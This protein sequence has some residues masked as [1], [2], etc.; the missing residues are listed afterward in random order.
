ML[1][2]RP[3]KLNTRNSYATKAFIFVKIPI[4]LGYQ[5][6][7][8]YLE[9]CPLKT[10]I[11]ILVI[12]NSAILAQATPIHDLTDCETT[13]GW[14]NSAILSANAPQGQFAVSASLP[15]NQ[16]GFVTFDFQNKGM[17]IS[18]KH[19]L[20]FWW[21][22]EGTGLKDLKIKVRNYPLVGGMEAIYTI[23]SGQTPPVGWQ[24]AIV[25][26]SKPQYDDWGGSPDLTRR[27]ITFR[28]E[29]GAQ[30][31]VQLFIDH[32]VAVD[33]I[34]T[35]TVASPVQT[36]ES[37]VQFDFDKDGSV[38]FSDFLILAQAFG[39]QQ[40]DPKF[41]SIVDINQDNTINFSDFVSF[42][43]VFGS[44]GTRWTIPVIIN[45]TTPDALLFQIGSQNS[46]LVTKS[47]S[48][49]TTQTITIPLDN[50]RFSGRNSAT[51][52]PIPLWVQV[53]GYP[54]TRQTWTTYVP[55][56]GP[57]RTYQQFV[58]AKQTQA[59]PIL[60]DFSYSGY[61][62]FAKSIP[63]IQ[64]DTF[65]VITFGAIPNDNQSDQLGIQRA[66]DAAERNNG[67]IVFF[68]PGEFLVNTMNDNNQSIFIR[69]SNIV[70]RGSGSRTGGTIIKMINHMPPTNPTQLWTSPYMFIFKPLNTS[71]K[72]LAQITADANRETFWITV[73]DVSNLFV[74]QWIILSMT[75]VSAVA[76]FLFPYQPEPSWTTIYSGGVQ[77]R[78]KHSIAEIQG[79]RV[80]INEPLHAS[81]NAL[82]GWTVR[83]Y[84]HLNEVGVED[85]CFMGNW[86]E[87]FV[88]HKDAIHDG[89]WSLLQLE[90]C[91]NSWV[92]RCS[93]IHAN[94]ALDIN[95]CSATSVYHITQ[96]GNKGHSSIAC[97][98]G[99]GVWIGLSEDLSAHHHGPGT[100]SRA[101]GTVYWR[102]DMQP[103]QRIDAHGAQPYANLLDC[104]NGGILYGSGA[105]I[106]NFP[107][108]LKHYVLWNFLHRGNQTHYDFW[109]QGQSRDRF[110]KP[111]IVGFHGDSVTFNESTLQVNE[112]HGSPV[113]PE[114][115]FEA[116]LNLRTGLAFP[117]WLNALKIEW[118]Q[119]RQTP[120]PNFPNTNF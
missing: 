97:E 29:T 39:T 14:S 30:S 35:W 37:I 78:E 111:I 58:Q 16:T 66:I 49:K 48:A 22:I 33:K 79:N 25:E 90:R 2:Y 70:L 91:V 110:V 117:E 104:V 31:N 68:P 6:F 27:Y 103:N 82:H 17:D 57:S 7:S 55:Q 63:H 10:C 107:N 11:I 118:E 113:D 116:Q 65:N 114:S 45:N 9:T 61:H 99:Y 84:L 76:D 86:L 74:G 1:P 94:R 95:T 112:S 98:N 120:L 77:V 4:I 8:F 89:G 51:T 50:S 72:T 20:S 41:K 69:G 56:E 60:P 92:R 47:I 59:E 87:E 119:I 100:S 34:F 19:S 32:I 105:S 101:V 5:I 38:G 80:R 73:N 43:F 75:S 81:I 108:H 96:A 54:Q 15:A 53:E 18:I 40:G 88:H 62:Y 23:W 46:T 52:F 115:L 28:T 44:N 93:F 102:Y 26:L 109:Q 83:E 21:K 3:A 12:L 106:E 71:D 42:A 67:G 13:T 85:I 64:T 36:K 24:L